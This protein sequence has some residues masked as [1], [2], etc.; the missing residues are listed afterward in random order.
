MFHVEQLEK[1]IELLLKWQKKI[2][3]ISS[4][5][6]SDLQNRHIKDS[7]QLVK[8]IPAETK[9]IIDIGSGAGLPGIPLAISTGIKTFLIESD[10]RKTIFLDEVIRQLDLNAVTINKRMEEAS[11][12]QTIEPVVIT[13][14]AVSA[15]ENIF[16]LLDSFLE[17]N[18]ITSYK[19]LLLKG[20]N[21][22]RE[23]LEAEKHWEFNAIYEKSET[24]S[25]SS[26]V[27]IDKFKRKAK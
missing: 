11:V 18:N 17:K 20:K 8:F 1:Y 7:L 2:N 26:I 12:P 27:L 16:E 19:L 4:D 22:S 6:I 10:L 15:L 13:A 5:S 9:T 24:D 25:E 21:V 23:T 3:L 14:R